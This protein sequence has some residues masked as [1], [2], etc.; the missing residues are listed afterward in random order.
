MGQSLSLC[1]SRSRPSRS[2]S[3]LSSPSLLSS[4]PS[5]FAPLAYHPSTSLASKLALSA[6]ESKDNED[7]LTSLFPSHHPTSLPDSDDDDAPLPSHSHPHPH[8]TTY[9]QHHQQHQQ[10]V[11]QRQPHRFPPHLSSSHLTS[12]PSESS[13]DASPAYASDAAYYTTDDDSPL[14][15]S[16]SIS[17]QPSPDR[18]PAPLTS[19]HH[20]QVIARPSSVAALPTLLPHPSPHQ[21]SLTSSASSVSLSKGV[22]V[23]G[24][25]GA[26]FHHSHSLQELASAVSHHHPVALFPSSSTSSLS[27]RGV[28]GHVSMDLSTPSPPPAPSCVSVSCAG[29]SKPVITRNAVIT[30]RPS[31]SSTSLSSLGSTSTTRTYRS[32]RKPL[33]LSPPSPHV[34]SHPT[35]VDDDSPVPTSSRSLFSPHFYQPSG[36]QPFSPASHPGTVLSLMRS[37]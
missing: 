22:R 23:S 30:I 35:H 31:V 33:S 8:P 24:G 13:L 25:A 27:S 15:S 37:L 28:A 32:H 16:S 26:G 3:S 29:D 18:I 5:S 19:S 1:G 21:R 20:I 17:A 12:F 34:T 7:G 36:T 4:S 2:P 11:K 9:H 14:S 6:A 10:A